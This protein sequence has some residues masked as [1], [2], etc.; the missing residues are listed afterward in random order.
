MPNLMSLNEWPDN[1]PVGV[2]AMGTRDVAAF[3]DQILNNQAVSKW[4][5]A[6]PQNM[7]V[8]PSIE[9][10]FTVFYCLESISPAAAKK[11]LSL[12]EKHTLNDHWTIYLSKPFIPRTSGQPKRLDAKPITDEPSET[13]EQLTTVFGG[14]NPTRAQINALH[15]LPNEDPVLI[16]NLNNHVEKGI[17]PD[18]GEIWSGHDLANLYLKRGI[19]TFTAL[20]AR[21]VWTGSGKAILR[22]DL[23]A[24]YFNQIGL[25]LYPTR[26]HFTTLMR[27]GMKEGWDR[28]RQAGY[29]RSWN[30]HCQVTGSTDQI[31]PY[32]PSSRSFAQARP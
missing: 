10:P 22:D 15:D 4:W 13:I 24:G 23:N 1:K 26:Q 28:Y 6:V 20:S 2:I 7:F 3:N 32:A 19:K 30:V 25:I 21:A 31:C 8:G 11:V 5:R 12:I 27:I 14:V 16:V 29:D 17:H 9:A 18:T